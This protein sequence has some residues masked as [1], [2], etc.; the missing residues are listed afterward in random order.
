MCE[1]REKLS[2]TFRKRVREECESSPKQKLQCIIK[3]GKQLSK[4]WQQEFFD[5]EQARHEAML[6]CLSEPQVL[7]EM[8]ISQVQIHVEMEDDEEA[9]KLKK[10]MSIMCNDCGV[11]VIG[12]IGGGNFC[13][14]SVPMTLCSSCGSWWD[15]CA[16]CSCH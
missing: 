4:E 10:E 3:I 2:D 5:F 6:D 7:P 14:C 15:S 11:Q 9:K 16:Q 1:I 8:K 13:Q 12:R